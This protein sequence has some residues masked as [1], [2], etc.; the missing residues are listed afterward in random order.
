MMETIKVVRGLT[1]TKTTTIMEAFINK[2]TI[3]L[4]I[5]PNT[6]YYQSDVSCSKFNPQ[7]SS[8]DGA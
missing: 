3:T 5:G 8:S 7:I 6:L 4:P 2:E 1:T